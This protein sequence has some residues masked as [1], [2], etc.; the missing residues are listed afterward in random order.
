MFFLKPVLTLPLLL[1]LITGRKSVRA[2]RGCEKR[3]TN[4]QTN[5]SI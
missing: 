1:K 5:L 4:Y 2:R 3:G